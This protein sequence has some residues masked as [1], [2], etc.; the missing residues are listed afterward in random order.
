MEL[1]ARIMGSSGIRA[2]IVMGVLCA[3]PLAL[4]PASRRLFAKTAESQHVVMSSVLMVKGRLAV[5]SVAGQSY[6]AKD[7]PERANPKLS[8]WI[9]AGQPCVVR[10]AK[11]MEN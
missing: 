6:V 3:S 5:S 2:V 4:A 1:G 8:V 10:N 11:T 9:V 7:V